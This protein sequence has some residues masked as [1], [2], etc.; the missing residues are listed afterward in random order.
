MSGVRRGVT[1]VG[2]VIIGS[3]GQK[4]LKFSWGL[5]QTSNDIAKALVVYMGMCLAME[6]NII[7]LVVIRDL[8]LIAKG[9]Q[10]LNK[11]VH[12]VLATMFSRIR[13]LEASFERIHY[14]H[15]LRTQNSTRRFSFGNHRLIP[16]C[17]SSHGY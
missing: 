13:A 6:R 10:K 14:F 8:E 7:G 3:D 11:N 15:I 12:P 4:I 1:G 16:C 2:G 17:R 5:G 9:L